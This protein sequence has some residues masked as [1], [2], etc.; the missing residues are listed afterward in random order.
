MYRWDDESRCVQVQASVSALITFRVKSD[1]ARGDIES[2][3]D[4]TSESDGEEAIAE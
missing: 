1:F 4:E 2:K 3:N